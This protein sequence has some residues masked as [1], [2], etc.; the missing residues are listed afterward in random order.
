MRRTRKTPI[1][2]S[3]CAS[4]SDEFK[5]AKD[6]P[7][8]SRYGLIFS[9]SIRA[10][11]FPFCGGKTFHH[12]HLSGQE[13]CEELS[14]STTNSEDSVPLRR[15]TIPRF[16]FIRPG[17]REAAFGFCV[18]GMSSNT[19]LREESEALMLGTSE[20]Y[21][22]QLSPDH[23]AGRHEQTDSHRKQKGERVDPYQ[24]EKA[25]M[26]KVLLLEWNEVLRNL[27]AEWLEM[28]G[29][30]AIPTQNIGQALAICDAQPQQIDVLVA[31]VRAFRTH[32]PTIRRTIERCQPAARFVFISGYDYESLCER[33]G[34]FALDA[35][36]LQKPFSLALL[37]RTIAAQLEPQYATA[38]VPQ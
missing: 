37:T 31:D 9:H 17:L 15:K 33:Y 29:Y 35:E 27:L 26:A 22:N 11:R 30:T 4:G 8:Q 3:C 38:G 21:R 12:C 19:R 34:Q 6:F 16:L 36:F 23:S 32:I 20:L 14:E 1:S 18:R 24:R 10:A 2:L 28:Q 13:I 5:S 7:A 25:H